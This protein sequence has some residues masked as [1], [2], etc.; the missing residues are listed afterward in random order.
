MKK[1]IF[2]LFMIFLL[3]VA[4]QAQSPTYIKLGVNFSSFRIE[5]GKSKPGICL[6]IGKDFYPLH[7]FNGFIFY[8]IFHRDVG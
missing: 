5:E 4:L 8:L 2:F 7:S 1:I 3:P 6:A